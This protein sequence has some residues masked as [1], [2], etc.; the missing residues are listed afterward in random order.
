MT[1]TEALA[2]LDDPDYQPEHPPTR[3][4]G[5][6]DVIA[7]W[8]PRSQNRWFRRYSGQLAPMPHARWDL[9]WVHSDQHR[10]LCCDSCIEDENDGYGSMRPE[11]CCCKG[12]RADADS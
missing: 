12:F 9:F 7:K 1:G 8:G 5:V 2:P 4:G 6:P 3:G 10:G 11:H